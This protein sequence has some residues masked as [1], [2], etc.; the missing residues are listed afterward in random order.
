MNKEY[1]DKILPRLKKVSKEDLQRGLIN[2]I[3]MASLVPDSDFHSFRHIGEEMFLIKKELK[4]RGIKTI[5]KDTE[6]GVFLSF[7]PMP[8]EL[9][10][11]PVKMV[12]PS[13][14]QL[15]H[16]PIAP[17]LPKHGYLSNTNPPIQLPEKM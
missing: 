17:D 6:Q 12:I 7:E 10:K 9:A 4:A 5:K 16:G 15:I 2:G 11:A 13:V 14:D 8:D 3:M 1:K